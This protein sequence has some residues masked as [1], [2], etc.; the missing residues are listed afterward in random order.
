MFW[1]CVAFS[2]FCV[3][4]EVGGSSTRK[5]AELLVH[6]IRPQHDL[7]GSVFCVRIVGIFGNGGI[8]NVRRDH[9]V[10]TSDD[11]VEV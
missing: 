1:F 8:W 9:L 7:I 4:S 2:N 6:L 3:R 10:F 5:P 11:S